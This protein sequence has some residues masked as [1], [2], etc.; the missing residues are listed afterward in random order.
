MLFQIL[1]LAGFEETSGVYF[2][3]LLWYRTY[4]KYALCSMFV[5]EL[6]IFAGAKLKGMSDCFDI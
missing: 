1:F 6:L 5:L 3:V 2:L 4:N